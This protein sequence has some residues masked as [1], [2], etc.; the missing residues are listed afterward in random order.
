MIITRGTHDPVM[1]KPNFIVKCR[2]PATVVRRTGKSPP[3][4]QDLHCG[5]PTEIGAG[6]G[7][8]HQQAQTLGLQAPQNWYMWQLVTALNKPPAGG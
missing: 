4:L 5:A 7:A 8:I 6:C 2:I 1:A 3:M